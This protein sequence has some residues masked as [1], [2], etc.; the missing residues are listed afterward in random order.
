MKKLMLASF[1]LASTLFANAQKTD[2]TSTKSG[3]ISGNN[4]LKLNLAYT[5]GGFP[6]LNY[7]RILKR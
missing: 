5:I 4:E 6:E 2:S 3:G 7:E 1:L